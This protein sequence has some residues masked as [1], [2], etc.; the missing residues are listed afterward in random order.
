MTELCT[1]FGM[2]WKTGYKRLGPFRSEG[3]RGLSDR[4]RRPRRL[5]R[6]ID[7]DVAAAILAA[8]LC[9]PTW[10]PK[11]L[12][13]RL[14]LDAPQVGW[15]AASTIGDLLKRHGL[16]GTR[17]RRRE[18]P[19]CGGPLSVSVAPN[20][21]WE[22]DFKDFAPRLFRRSRPFDSDNPKQVRKFWHCLFNGPNERIANVPHLR[23]I[24]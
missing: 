4:S 14:M 8:R 7:S 6:V 20:D 22:A 18:V 10:G 24:A 16:N 2:S 21:V 17:R 9:H 3:E 1:C 19:A 5:G 15:P 23:K 13:G 12:R 11:K